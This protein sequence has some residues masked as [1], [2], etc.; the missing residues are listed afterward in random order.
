MFFLIMKHTNLGIGPIGKDKKNLFATGND[1]VF[2]L[3]YERMLY[4]SRYVQS[5]QSRSIGWQALID[6][7]CLWAYA[8]MNGYRKGAKGRSKGHSL[9]YSLFYNRCLLH[10]LW[11]EGNK[12]IHVE[13]I[14]TYVPNPYVYV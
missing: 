3:Q 12:P 13:L 6:T 11:S 14:E 9:R 1:T 10:K 8:L 7:I 5:K 4:R 2:Q